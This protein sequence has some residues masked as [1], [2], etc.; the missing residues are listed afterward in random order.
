MNKTAKKWGFRSMIVG[1]LLSL[2]LLAPMAQAESESY[3]IDTPGMHAFIQFRVKHLGFSWL[4]GRF[5]DF[6]GK[7]SYEE[8]FQQSSN[9]EVTINTTSL[10]SNHA[11]RDKHL[12]GAK[13]LDV[14]KFPEAKFVSTAYKPKGAMAGTL[15]GNFTLKGVTK[16]ISI[17]VEQIGSG[18]DPWGGFRR[19]FEG[20]T[21]FKAADYGIKHPAVNEVELI[22]SVEGIR[23]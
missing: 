14:E 23:E 9:V 17:E 6:N 4:Y 11:E 16:P 7:F 19:G 12:R 20:K 18:E 3:K 21:S 22:L 5:N 15:E 13:F 10:D 8:A 1:S 2:S